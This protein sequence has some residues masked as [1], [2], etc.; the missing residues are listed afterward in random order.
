MIH[1][2]KSI[3]SVA[4]LCTT[5]LSGVAWAETVDLIILAG[6]SNMVGQANTNSSVPGS[7]AADSQVAFYYD[8]TNTAG[9]FSDDSAQTFGTLQPWQFNAS[10]QR[11]GPE[12]SLGRE[13][14][15]AGDLNPAMIKVAI[16]GS[17]IARWQPGPPSG[18]DYAALTTAVTDGI[19]E[20]M[21]RGDS[22][23][24]LGMVWL[25]GESD[26]IN[27]NRAATYAFSLDSFINGFRAEMN[28][29]FPSVG[30]DSMHAFLVEPANWKN[31]SNPGIASQANIDLVHNALM[32]FAAKDDDASF[33]ST[34]DFTTFEDRLIH[35]S[36]TDQL[37]LGSRIAAA[38]RETIVPEPASC[39]LIVMTMLAS[40][41]AVRRS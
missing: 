24:L 8:V 41:A 17:N 26:V 31:G 40:M 1:I 30:F 37:V 3:C 15:N 35:F 10:S 14:I 19:G 21:L 11:F 25:Q 16:G 22:I 33:I 7:D 2:T 23:N 18:I 12:I 36:G 27:T 29:T 34:S 6:Q 4:L 9:S 32:N 39:G 20:I 5:C 38:V 13:L 28:T